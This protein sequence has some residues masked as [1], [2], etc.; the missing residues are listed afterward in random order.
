MNSTATMMIKIG[1]NSIFKAVIGISKT[2][3][4]LF[5][6]QEQNS[7]SSRLGERITSH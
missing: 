7:T 6:Y 3:N 1:G 4:K 5:S 2:A